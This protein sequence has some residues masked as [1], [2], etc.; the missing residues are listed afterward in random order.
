MHW[1]TVIQWDYLVPSMR[2]ARVRAI[3]KPA[4]PQE[5]RVWRLV[6]KQRMWR[7]SL[8]LSRTGIDED[9]AAERTFGRP[10]PGGSVLA[11][12]DRASSIHANLIWNAHDN[13]QLGVEYAYW[14]FREVTTD[15]NAQ[16]EQVMASAKFLF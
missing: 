6:L 9:L 15:G 16:A 14:D 3:G 11:D 13:L 7:S 4:L 1:S 5:S 10:Q 2:T 12:F 8:V